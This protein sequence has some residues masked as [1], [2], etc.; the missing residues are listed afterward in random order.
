MT[1]SGGGT[2][3]VFQVDAGVTATLSGLTITD[4]L[5]L[6]GG[7]IE[8][9][10][11]VT[12]TNCTISGNTAAESAAACGI[13]L[14]HADGHQLHSRGQLGGNATAAASITLAR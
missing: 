8:N 4:G 6:A 10:G 1:I 12:L 3:G 7:G 13:K 2:S 5:A 9:V 14:W 11:T